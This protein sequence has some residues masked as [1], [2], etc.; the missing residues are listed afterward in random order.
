MNKIQFKDNQTRKF[1]VSA[2][3]HDLTLMALSSP[4]KRFKAQSPSL[5]STAMS[6][7]S[8]EGNGGSNKRKLS[9]YEWLLSS[10]GLLNELGF[11]EAPRDKP[12]LEFNHPA[13]LKVWSYTSFRCCDG[14]EGFWECLIPSPGQCYFENKKRK[15]LLNIGF[16]L[17]RSIVSFFI[18]IVMT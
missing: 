13:V 1:V 17:R 16:S 3:A 4:C 14:Q 15:Y 7:G 8:N 6:S 9:T 2:S 5:T 11:L 18:I 12:V 10:V